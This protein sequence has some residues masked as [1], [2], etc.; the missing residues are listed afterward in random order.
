MARSSFLVL[1]FLA[2]PLPA[3]TPAAQS[4]SPN[5]L[6]RKVVEHELKADSEDRTHW[7][8]R[9]VTGIPAPAREK[10]VVETGNGDLTRLDRIDNRPLTREQRSAE[11]RRIHAFVGDTGAQLKALRASNADDQKSTDLFRMLPDAFLFKNAEKKGDTQK[12]T[13][14]PNPEYRARSLEA[15]VFHRMSGYIVVNTREMRLVEIAGALTHGV[16]FAGG[17][18]GHLDPGG[19]FDVRLTE[20]AP[21]VWKVC[22]LKVNMHGRVLFFK[23]VGDQEDETRSDFHQVPDGVT[24][25]QAEKMLTKDDADSRSGS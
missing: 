9:D 5:D 25:S 12:L 21:E 11:S 2:I 4:S 8:Y 20:V 19:T 15:Y 17:L 18:L 24:F 13:F 1:L 16:E 7:M 14:E 10:T 22:R 3:Q 6:V 23:T